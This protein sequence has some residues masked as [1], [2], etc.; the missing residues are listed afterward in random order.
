MVFCALSVVQCWL[1]LVSWRYLERFSSYIADTILWRTDRQTDG[2]T[3]DSGKN[4][5]SPNPKG[6]H[7]NPP[8][9]LLQSSLSSPQQ[10]FDQKRT[11]GVIVL[12]QTFLWSCTIFPMNLSCTRRKKGKQKCP[13]RATSRSRSQPLTPG[14]REKVTQINVCLAN[15]QMHDKH[16]SS[17]SQ[18]I[19][20]LK[21]QKKHI[22]KEQGKTKDEALRNVN[23]RA[24]QNKNNIRIT[25]FERSVVYTAG[26]FKGLSLYK[27][28][29]G[30]RYNS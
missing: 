12:L 10:N 21:G 16:P 8:R 4:S 5:M 6:E 24:T 22:E 18:V 17:P 3:E 1:I 30:S 11:M 20:M 28:H 23:Y 15:K 7:N 19:K 27:L 13:G 29:P 9:S 14:W 26:G 25:A 2:W